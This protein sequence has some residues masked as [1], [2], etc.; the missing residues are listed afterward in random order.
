L[1]VAQALCYHAAILERLEIKTGT[2]TFAER[3]LLND[4]N[5]EMLKSEN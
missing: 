5:A 3:D 2:P 1:P 4:L